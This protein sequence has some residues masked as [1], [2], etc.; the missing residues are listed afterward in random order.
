[1]DYRA[2]PFPQFNT[3]ATFLASTHSTDVENHVQNTI[4]A[5]FHIILILT[6]PAFR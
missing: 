6:H 4:M 1:M 2:P 3:S 5:K